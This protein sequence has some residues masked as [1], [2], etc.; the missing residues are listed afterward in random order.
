MPAQSN[1]IDSV[2]ISSGLEDRYFIRSRKLTA[3]ALARTVCVR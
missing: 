1:D 2:K 3:G